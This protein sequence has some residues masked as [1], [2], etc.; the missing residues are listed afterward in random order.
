[1]LGVAVLMAA[2]TMPGQTVLMALFNASIR[3][4]LGLSIEQIS[5]AYTVGTIIASLPL[6]L[7]GRIADR[8][9]LRRTV[10]GVVLGFIVSL[11]L[12]RE[13]TG[14]VALGACFFLV[15]FLGQG[16]LGMLAGH[17]I[18]MWFERRLGT[19]HSVL[20]VG[21]FAAA[22][23]IAPFPTAKMIESLGW[24]TTLLVWAVIVGVLTVPA[25]LFVFR[26]RPEDIGQH[27]DGDPVE[28][29]THDVLHGG[30]PP[31]GDP[32]FTVRQAVATRAFWIVSI[33]ML[34]SGLVGTALLFHMQTM[35]QQAGLE[36]TEKQV[37][38]AIQPWPIA[39]GGAML[40]VGWL[41]DRFH[42]AKILPVALV[43]QAG[44]ILL[45]FGAVRGMVG[46]S[47]IVPLMAV[48]MGVYGVSQATIAGVANPTIARYFGRTHHGAIRG[49]IT[50]AIVMGTGGGPW[51]FA[52]G[53]SA[54]GRDFGPVML[55]F[56]CLALPLG[57]AAAML[58]KPT[59]P[60]E[61]D[62][63]PDWVTDEPDP[64][65]ASL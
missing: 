59:P 54:A 16:S 23:A 2:A 8:L 49:F 46:A 43:F 12:L 32:G 50:T 38:I 48:G 42:P 21:G 5:G 52:F 20:A 56:A 25:L 34:M 47:M 39:F 57:I 51:L 9:G 22:S 30:A 58:R 62:L 13:A 3:E 18:A 11:L 55:V 19:A 26:N 44:A 15:R 31:P 45:C 64:P 24:Q 14:I 1:M 53:Y 27:L 7:V 37:A 33:N 6:P 63:T 61:R 65:G 41:V 40:V 36:G 29:E 60:R 35:L 10:A 17:T 4:S 28:H